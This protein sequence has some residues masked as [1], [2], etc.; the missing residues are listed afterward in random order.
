MP[1]FIGIDEAGLAPNLGPLVITA[2]VW[3]T[4]QPLNSLN[5]WR[6]FEGIISQDGDEDGS[7][8]HIADSKEVHQSSKGLHAL[9]LGVLA[10][11]LPARRSTR[12]AVLDAIAAT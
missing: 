3:E 8:L 6:D 5:F 1:L 9:E 4:T 2:T 12:L 11:L 7:C 10:S